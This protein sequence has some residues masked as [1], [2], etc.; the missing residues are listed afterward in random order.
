MMPG[1]AIHTEKMRNVSLI[2]AVTQC[3]ALKIIESPCDV[4]MSLS[5]SVNTPQDVFF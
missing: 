4:D 3:V 5:F 2:S 1:G